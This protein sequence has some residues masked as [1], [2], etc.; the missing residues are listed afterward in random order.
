[1]KIVVRDEDQLS[2]GGLAIHIKYL[3]SGIEQIK[4]RV[5]HI[6]RRVWRRIPVVV[7]DSDS[8]ADTSG[9]LATVTDETN[10]V[11][12]PV[13]ESGRVIAINIALPSLP[14]LTKVAVVYKQFQRIPRAFFLITGT[15]CLLA[16]VLLF[17][18][19]NSGSGPLATAAPPSSGPP[20]LVKGTPNYATLL[21]AGKTIAQLGGWTRISPT[22]SNPVYAFVDHT[23][24]VQI[25]VSEQPIPTSFQPDPAAKIASMAQNF[26]ATDKFE[27]GT[28]TV[29]IATAAT[30]QQ[31]VIL[32][33]DNVLVLIRSMS[34][35]S[36]NQWAAYVNALR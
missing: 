2:I 16:V 3:N 29:Y 5:R 6:E 13:D 9:S 12:E 24:N 20:P 19:N 1:M 30:N 36:N 7:E 32:A 10:P 18:F 34:L 22:K 15:A 23:D 25:A 4:V 27:V 14:K 31:E 8:P 35:L 21:P 11:E 33:K 28:T 17:V 26:N